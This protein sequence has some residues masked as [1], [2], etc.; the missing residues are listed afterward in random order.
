MADR[1]VPMNEA[2]KLKKQIEVLKQAKAGLIT[3]DYLIL[4]AGEWLLGKGCNPVF[5]ELG[6]S[7][8]TEIP[9]A[10]G[11][12]SKGSI[13]VE[14]KISVADFKAE[15]KKDHGLGMGERRYFLMT[16]ELYTKVEKDI[17]HK[18]GVVIL[19]IS[20]WPRQVNNMS[21]GLFENDV[22]AELYYL[23]NRI[24]SIQNFGR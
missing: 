16:R 7:A 14:C 2:A 20:G 13:K 17:I 10:I 6:S 24:L 1:V 11:W 15:L 5:T 18:W 4:K 12:S 19:D 21:S 8:S 9:D 3:H 23:R 22:T